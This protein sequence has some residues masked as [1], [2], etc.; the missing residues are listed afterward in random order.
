[1]SLFRSLF[2]FVKR[3]SRVYSKKRIISLEKELLK[4]KKF[5]IISDNCWGGAVYQWYE[6]PYNTP[7]VGMAI[8]GECYIKLLSNFNYYMSQKLVFKPHTETKH[9]TISD[10]N[11]HP[12]G[13]LDDVEIH[14]THFKTEEEAKLKWERR[15]ERMLMEKDLNNY[16]FKLCDTKGADQSMFEKFY[17]LPFKNKIS[18]IQKDKKFSNIESQIGI[19]ERHRINKS[20]VPNGVKLFKISFLYFD[21][22]EWL[23]NKKVVRTRFKS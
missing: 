3:K 7:F 12:M 8:H 18:F 23:L 9:K 19:F 11:Y 2:V 6:R 13:L 15:T 22:T 5:V 1:M 14:F 16:Y 4:N 17:E 21:L 10:K 20:N